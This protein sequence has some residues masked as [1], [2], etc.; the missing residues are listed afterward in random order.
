M[1]LRDI[2]LFIVVF[3]GIPFMLRWPLVGIMYWVWIGMANPHLQSYGAAQDFPFAAL[4]A[5]VTMASLVISREKLRLKPRPEVLILLVLGGW[6]TMTTFF[7]LNPG[8][9]WPAWE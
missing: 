9:A 1:G 5:F 8:G 3:G 4:V 2:V 6:M 7:A